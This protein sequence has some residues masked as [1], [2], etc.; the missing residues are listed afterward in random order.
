MT[1]MR[2]VV[3][4]MC[5]AV[6]CV[7]IAESVAAEDDVLYERSSWSGP[8]P[9][10]AI[11]TETLQLYSSGRVVLRGQRNA[12]WQFDAAMMQRITDHI[13]SSELMHKACHPTHPPVTDYGA[14]VTIT[15]D[16]QTKIIQFPGC[17]KELAAIGQ[18]VE[19]T[20][21]TEDSH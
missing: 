11:C 21:K 8:C 18:L 9:P 20:P 4:V 15:L 13:R 17:E 5:V 1:Q 14:Q 19:L 12:T 2:D 7:C 3:I 6:V 10:D 16:H